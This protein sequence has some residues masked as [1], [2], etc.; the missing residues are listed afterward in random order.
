MN[1]QPQYFKILLVMLDMHVMTRD[2]VIIKILISTS[3]PTLWN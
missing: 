1:K 3:L 2:K